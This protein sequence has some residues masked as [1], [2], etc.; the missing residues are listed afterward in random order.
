M[1]FSRQLMDSPE[2]FLQ[3]NGE[4]SVKIAL[5]E[6]AYNVGKFADHESLCILAKCLKQQLFLVLWPTM[7]E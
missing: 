5:T 1:S 2:N 6:M 4:E 3:N 7:K